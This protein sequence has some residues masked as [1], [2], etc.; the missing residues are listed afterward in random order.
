MLKLQEDKSK[1]P[2]NKKGSPEHPHQTAPTIEERFWAVVICEK[3]SFAGTS[4]A[5][6]KCRNKTIKIRDGTNNW[7]STQTPETLL[8]EVHMRSN[9]MKKSCACREGCREVLSVLQLFWEQMLNAALSWQWFPLSL[10]LNTKQTEYK[11]FN[12]WQIPVN[13]L[14]IWGGNTPMFSQ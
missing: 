13:L 11:Y 2:Q 4:L 10:R 3:T 5:S 9:A 1:L 7:Y 6:K 14:N 12:W 8:S